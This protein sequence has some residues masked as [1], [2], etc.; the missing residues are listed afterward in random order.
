MSKTASAKAGRGRRPAPA[1]T[2][3]PVRRRRPRR[4]AACRR[5]GRA[6]PTARPGVAEPPGGGRRAAADLQHP[7]PAHVA[8]QAGVGLA[9]PFGAPHEVDVAEE[10]A[11]LGLVIVGVGVPPL[12]VRAPALGRADTARG[13]SPRWGAGAAVPSVLLS[14]VRPRAHRTS[15]LAELGQAASGPHGHPRLDDSGEFPLS[16]LCRWRHREGCTLW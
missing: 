6:R 9:Q 3:T 15:R 14:R 5:T 8:E 4:A 7:R 1:G 10:V 13:G 11:V 2:W 16:E 12:P